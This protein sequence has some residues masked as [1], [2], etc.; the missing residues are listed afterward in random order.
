MPIA[1][2]DLDIINDIEKSNGASHY[3]S[4]VLKHLLKRTSPYVYDKIMLE[5]IIRGDIKL[6]GNSK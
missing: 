3:P 4:S 5:L 2:T 1:E 6:G